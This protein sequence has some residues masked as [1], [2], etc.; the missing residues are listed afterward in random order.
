[1][2]SAKENQDFVRELIA[3]KG[4]TDEIEAEAVEIAEAREEMKDM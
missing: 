4:L 2:G 1:M 3:K